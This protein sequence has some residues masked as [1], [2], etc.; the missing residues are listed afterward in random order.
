[1][2]CI[3]SALKWSNSLGLWMCPGNFHQLDFT[4]KSHHLDSV[5]GSILNLRHLFTRICIDNPLWGHPE[6]LHQLYFSLA[7]TVKSCPNGSEC[8]HYRSAII[9]FDCIKGGDPRKSFQPS[10][11]FL[12]NV[13][14]VRNIEG[15]LIILQYEWLQKTHQQFNRCDQG[16]AFPSLAHHSHEPYS[17]HGHDNHYCHWRIHSQ[18]NSQ[19]PI[20][21]FP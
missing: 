13:S 20:K 8:L 19:F 2:S 7:G 10:Q 6:T 5:I 16:T 11:M 9:A 18:L 4:I 21:T 17:N 12:Q 15:I 1:M 3:W 14:Q